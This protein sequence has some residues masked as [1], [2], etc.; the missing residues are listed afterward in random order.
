MFDEINVKSVLKAT[1]S[2]VQWEIQEELDG[3]IGLNSSWYI[4]E[5][6]C[7]CF[8]SFYALVWMLQSLQN[9]F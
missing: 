5:H 8:K 9:T 6:M 7:K 4:K 1:L 2:K 3:E